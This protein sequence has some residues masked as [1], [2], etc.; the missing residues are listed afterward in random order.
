M[1]YIV[2]LETA[3]RSALEGFLL[4]SI[5]V[6]IDKYILSLKNLIIL[7]RKHEGNVISGLVCLVLYLLIITT[8]A[9]CAELRWWA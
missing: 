8:F 2:P 9:G 4:L 6:Q 5:M 7:H 1:S 3:D